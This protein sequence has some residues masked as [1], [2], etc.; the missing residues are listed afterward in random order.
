MTKQG[1]GCTVVVVVA[2]FIV[3]GAMALGEKFLANKTIPPLPGSKIRVIEYFNQ[4]PADAIGA[5]VAK[6]I[7]APEDKFQFRAFSRALPI[8]TFDREQFE[9]DNPDKY[10]YPEKNC[11][12]GVEVIQVFTN[13]PNINLSPYCHT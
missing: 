2:A 7:K 3:F 6:D 1:R 10:V 9:S 5:I 12:E 4:K 13:D 11:R 8:G